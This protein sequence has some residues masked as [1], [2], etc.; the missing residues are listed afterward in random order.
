MM[1][2]KHKFHSLLN[3][4]RSKLTLSAPD[5]TPAIL[6]N[7]RIEASP[8][9]LKNIPYKRIAIFHSPSAITF[10]N[11]LPQWLPPERPLLPNNRITPG[12]LT[13]MCLASS[14]WLP[15]QIL[16]IH[17]LPPLNFCKNLCF[18]ID[19]GSPFL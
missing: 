9:Q 10:N 7:Q 17:C 4:I 16:R 19:Q 6:S 1:G 18:S 14:N 13:R 2:L 3:L 11:G 12:T 15:N 5:K 8:V